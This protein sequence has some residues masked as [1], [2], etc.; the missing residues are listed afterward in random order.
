MEFEKLS[1]LVE[2]LCQGSRISV[3][4][5]DISGIL[6]QEALELPFA[7][8]IHSAAFCDG[9]KS[10]RRGYRLCIKCKER[11]NRKAVREGQPFSGYCPCGLYEAVYPVEVDGSVRCV[12]YV[13]NLLPD[14]EAAEKRLERAC[15]ITGVSPERLKNELDRGETELSP[16]DAMKMAQLIGSYVK[17]LCRVGEAAAV[18]PHHWA[19]ETLIEY[20]RL[21][22]AYPISLRDL[23]RLYYI[24]EKYIGRLFKAQTGKTFHQYLTGVRLEEAE[25]QLLT[26]SRSITDIAES[27]GFESASYFNRIFRERWSMTP[28]EYRRRGGETAGFSPENLVK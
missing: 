23:A 18:S 15:R 27:C 10:T 17:L 24:N 12:V 11:A 8:K 6:Q 13:G 19:V 25:R 16:E 22:Y 9:A 21:H 28:S 7:R 3:C 5:C 14:R 2:L 1:A 4:V 20:V 26:T